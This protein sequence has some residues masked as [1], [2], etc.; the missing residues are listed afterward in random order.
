[1]TKWE[2]GER[3]WEQMQY[4]GKKKSEMLKGM[5]GQWN[6]SSTPPHL[7]PGESFRD[8]PLLPQLHSVLLGL[9]VS[10]NCLMITGADMS[11]GPGHHGSQS[12]SWGESFPEIHSK[13][14]EKRN[15]LSPRFTN[16]NDSSCEQ[17]YSLPNGEHPFVLG[18]KEPGI[19]K[20][21]LTG[22]MGKRQELCQFRN[23]VWPKSGHIPIL[24]SS[25]SQNILFL[26]KQVWIGSL[27]TC[28]HT[29]HG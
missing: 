6:V 4:L 28:D 8:R 1:M 11:L 12:W 21:R 23:S 14:L 19:N 13:L 15:D 17:P 10:V 16:F 24:P 20:R 26:L 25:M 2:A 29:Y 5:W 9:L 7:L 22:G 27:V 3:R 18:K